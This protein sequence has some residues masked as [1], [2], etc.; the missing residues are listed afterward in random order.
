MGRPLALVLPW[1]L[2]PVP[3]SLAAQAPPRYTAA[4]LSCA[5]FEES[6]RT[7][8]RAQ[9]GGVPY[10]ER[11]DR[12]G[13]LVVLGVPDARGVRFTAWYDSLTVAHLGRAARLEPDTDGLIGGR[14][15]G[16]LTP[17]GAVELAVRPF[18][19]PELLAVS[20][21]SDALADFFPPLPGSA[22]APG[23]TWTDSLGLTMRRLADSAARSGAVARYRW[24]ILSRSA[25]PLAADTGL[26]L[27]QEAED[28]GQLAWLDEAGVLGWRRTVT[29]ETQV[30]RGPRGPG[31]H[32]GRVR[33]EISVRRITDPAACP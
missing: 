14:W 2:A 17:S 5:A 31:T 11:G 26:R 21:L 15:E 20:D 16:W 19:P 1:L 23:T 9:E 33:Q 10:E 28:E 22:M 13:R 24:T 18:M 27:R 12:F 6:V 32:R 8:V 7:E 29:V 3:W 25:P 4:P 30:S